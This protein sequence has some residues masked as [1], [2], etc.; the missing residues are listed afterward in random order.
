MGAQFRSLPVKQIH[1][2]LYALVWAG[3]RFP[4]STLQHRSLH[5]L[6]E[7]NFGKHREVRFYPYISERIPAL[8][9]N[10]KYDGY[11]AYHAAPVNL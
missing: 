7:G 1:N 4:C 9:F 8:L 2:R 3:R 10:H 11:N 5:L 6:L